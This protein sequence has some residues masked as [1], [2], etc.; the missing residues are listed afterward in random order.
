MKISFKV[1]DYLPE[2]KQIVVKYCLRSSNTPIDE[3]R[4]ISVDLVRLNMYTPELFKNS[5]SS[6]LLHSIKRRNDNSIP[7]DENT[8]TED[9][10]S[11]G[12]VSIE[13]YV[14]KVVEHDARY[15]DNESE[16]TMGKLKEVII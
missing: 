6:V 5:L 16:E 2:T 15:Y 4:A 3:S 1:T 11:L 7:L 10:E 8:Q 9:V 12:L 13:D 14:G